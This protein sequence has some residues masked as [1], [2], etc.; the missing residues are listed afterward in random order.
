MLFFKYINNNNKYNI[1]C[2]HALHPVIFLE[3]D[4]DVYR[5]RCIT[6]IRYN[7][8][9]LSLYGPRKYLLYIS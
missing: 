3:T 6:E 5:L 8:H 2:N 4:S 1:N 7:L 9:L